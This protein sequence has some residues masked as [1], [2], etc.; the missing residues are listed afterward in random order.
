LRAVWPVSVTLKCELAVEPGESVSAALSE[1]TVAD[2]PGGVVTFGAGGV[3]GTAT[4]SGLCAALAGRGIGG[5][6]SFWSN[7]AMRPGATGGAGFVTLTSPR[8]LATML[9]SSNKRPSD[10]KPMKVPLVRPMPMRRFM[11]A[12]QK[13]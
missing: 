6:G 8:L 2:T 13:R 7:P 1:L 10:A 9:G 12:L 5:G 11:P 3:V 4:Y